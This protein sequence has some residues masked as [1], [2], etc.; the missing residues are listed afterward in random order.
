MLASSGLLAVGLAG[1]SFVLLIAGMLV[2]GFGVGLFQVAYLDRVAASLPIGERGVAGAL[3]MLT[4]S[5]GLVL[6]AALLML[7]FQ[8]ARDAALARGVA[9][10]EAFGAG[11]RTTLLFAAALPLAF[12]LPWMLR[13]RRQLP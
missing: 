8:T 9:A 5:L 6:G 10:G 7:S 1:G 4:R 2:Q 13:R 11:F 12:A 3:A